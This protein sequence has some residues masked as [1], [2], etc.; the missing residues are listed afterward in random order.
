MKK[1]VFWIILEINEDRPKFIFR[2]VMRIKIP[3]NVDLTNLDSD[4]MGLKFV[5]YFLGIKSF[6]VNIRELQAEICYDAFTNNVSQILKSFNKQ[7]IKY[8]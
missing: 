1:I 3:N 7:I 5:S 6:L 8:T 2:L 4:L